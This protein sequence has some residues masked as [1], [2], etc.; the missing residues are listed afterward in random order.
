[1]K[2]ER[3]LYALTGARDDFVERAYPER[4]RPARAWVKYAAAAACLCVVIAGALALGQ[5]ETALPVIDIPPYITHGGGGGVQKISDKTFYDDTPWTADMELTSLPVFK[6]GAFDPSFAGKPC[7]LSERQM[8]KRLKK[9]AEALG[10]EIYETETRTS[11]SSGEA[12]YITAETDKG[13]L[14]AQ[15]DGTVRWW[16]PYGSEYEGVPLPEEYAF[17]ESES[18]EQKERERIEYLAGLY[19][20]FLGFEQPATAF[21]DYGY[22]RRIAYDAAGDDVSDILNYFFE[23]ASFSVSEDGAYLTG[24]LAEDKFSVLEKLG[25]YPLISIDEAVERLLAGQYQTICPLEVPGEEYILS[26]ELTYRDR[27]LEEIL[28]PYYLF[29]VEVLP[30]GDYLHEGERGFGYF[31]VPAI[32][33]EYIGNAESWPQTNFLTRSD[34]EQRGLLK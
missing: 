1:M 7:G 21:E 5:R 18:T 26:V 6:N 4:A 28:L 8:K 13:V 12:M 32:G 2:G 33:S 29:R 11:D 16:Q 30:D 25:D 20:D 22:L 9:A 23:S 24:I 17:P 10:L 19:S 3:I 14:E 31:Y 15:A 34:L 27:P